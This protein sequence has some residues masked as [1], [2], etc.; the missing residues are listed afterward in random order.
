MRVTD[1]AGIPVF[2]M[3]IYSQILGG[4]RGGLG[5]ADILPPSVFPAAKPNTLLH[6]PPP[7]C[8][9][10]LPHAIA[11]DGENGNE[12]RGQR[13]G[14]D[15]EEGIAAHG[16]GADDARAVFRIYRQPDCQGREATGHGRRQ[17]EL[18][19]NGTTKSLELR[20]LP[21]KAIHI[22]SRESVPLVSSDR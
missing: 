1:E 19:L 15:C 14:D 9:V 2:T 21:N 13:D 3:N 17:A 12:N 11:L 4:R 18:T 7:G 6:L 20:D 8:P 16:A 5:A 22:A 10:P